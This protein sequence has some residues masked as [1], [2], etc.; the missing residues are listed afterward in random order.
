MK[1]GKTNKYCAGILA[2]LVATALG[3]T[4]A[5]AEEPAPGYTRIGTVKPR[6]ARQIASSNWSVG[7]ETMGRDYTIYANWKRYLGPLG[8]KKARIQSGWAKTEQTK[9]KY[10][11]AWLDEIIP[12]MVEQGVEPWVCLCYGNP[13]YP[14]GGGTGLGGGLPSSPEAKRAWE[15]FV[16]AFVDRYREHVTQWEIWNEPRGGRKA[17]PAYGDLVIRTAE[18]IRKRQ[19]KARIVVAADAS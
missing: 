18:V 13:I 4:A 5:P 19:P 2:V 7:A 15:A 12:D 8:V 10:D 1:P 17:V 14:D 9:G 11:W 16:G 3:V 6:H